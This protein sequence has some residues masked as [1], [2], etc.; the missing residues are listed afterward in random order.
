MHAD[1]F[2]AISPFNAVFCISFGLFLLLLIGSAVALRGK[3]E[4]TRARV[5]I[6]ACIVTF[7]GFFVYKYCLSIDVDYDRLIA[8][9]GGFN[10][11]GELPLHL[12]NINMILI[13]IAVATRNRSLMSFCFFVGPLGAFMA[14]IMPGNGF[15]G[16]SVLL[17]RNLGYYGTHF[18]VLIEGLAVAA[19]GFYRPRFRDLPKTVL[20]IFL[21]ALAVFGVNMLLR[22]TGLHPK[23]NYFYTVETEGNPLLNLFYGLIPVPFLY[24]I[25]CALILGVYASIITAGF[26]LGDRLRA[27]SNA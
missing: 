3:S 19:Y 23:A 5:L 15:D 4:Q 12:C 16:Y 10:W 17:A 11:W 9:M 6:G 18:M 1:T 7:I 22:T 2:W 25:P 13:P 21:I 24:M 14:L 20:T 27:K 8:N 26:A